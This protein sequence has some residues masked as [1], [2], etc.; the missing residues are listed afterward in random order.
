MA[1]G[2]VNPVAFFLP[3]LDFLLRLLSLSL[4]ERNLN[5]VSLQLFG[6]LV[7]LLK[8]I[9]SGGQNEDHWDC[10]GRIEAD[11]VVVGRVKGHE[12]VAHFDF[13]EVPDS[14]DNP[15]RPDGFLR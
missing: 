14:E 15:V 10:F 9:D 1:V 12:V 2:E 5:E 8:G 11:L 7:E 4:A 6:L 3:I 13:H